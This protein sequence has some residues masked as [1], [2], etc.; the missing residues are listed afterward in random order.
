MSAGIG[1]MDEGRVPARPTPPPPEENPTVNSAQDK[2]RPTSEP[3]DQAD[4]SLEAQ[5]AASTPRPVSESENVEAVRS[6]LEE[7]AS[8]VNEISRFAQ[9]AREDE[10]TPAERENAQAQV[11]K[12]VENVLKTQEATQESAGRVERDYDVQGQILKDIATLGRIEISA[13]KAITFEDMTT[14]K[15]A[16]LENPENAVAVAEQATLD[17][18]QMRSQL[19]NVASND[20]TSGMEAAHRV[21]TAENQMLNSRSVQELIDNTK[22]AFEQDPTAIMMAAQGVSSTAVTRLLG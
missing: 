19:E 17:V 15:D 16:S 22:S 11:D 21:R 7:M 12:G 13:E 8:E 9:R 2:S 3:S 10:L 1:P 20:A 14:G 5:K 18:S 6:G 4:V